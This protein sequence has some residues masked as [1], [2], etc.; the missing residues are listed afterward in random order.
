MTGEASWT[1]PFTGE[2]YVMLENVT[3]TTPVGGMDADNLDWI[4]ALDD[5]TGQEYWYNIK[6]G[7][8][9]WA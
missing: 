9:S 1:K 7:E 8:S 3:N 2:D 5:T 6:T 4:S